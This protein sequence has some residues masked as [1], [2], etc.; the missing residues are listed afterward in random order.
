MAVSILCPLL[1]NSPIRAFVS[2]ASKPVSGTSEPSV[3]YINSDIENSGSE[4]GG[5]NQGIAALKQP[6]NPA[7]DPSALANARNYRKYF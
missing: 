5:E 3:F 7:G 4:T 6:K 2:T 1:R